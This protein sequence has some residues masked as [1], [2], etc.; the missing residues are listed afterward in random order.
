MERLSANWKWILTIALPIVFAV[1]V[2]LPV[3][4]KVRAASGNSFDDDIV[5]ISYDDVPDQS[6][7]SPF[8]IVKVKHY[9]AAPVAP[10]SGPEQ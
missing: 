7:P 5:P 6:K 4:P 3:H 2:F 10:P 1:F 9:R 8:P